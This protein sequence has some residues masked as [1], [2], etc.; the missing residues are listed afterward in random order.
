MTTLSLNFQSERLRFFPLQEEHILLINQ[1]HCLPM[2]AQ[3]NTIGIPKDIQTTANLLAQR[4][5]PVDKN[6]YGWA[7]FDSSKNFVGEAGMTLSPQR[8]KKAEIS[9][10]LHPNQWGIGLGT[11]VARRLIKF[12]FISLGLHRIEAGVA[13]SN[14]ASI[15][16]LEKAG[17]LR[18]GI[19][20]KILPLSKGWSDNF[21]YAILKEEW[22]V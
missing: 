3:F 17:M 4:L 15:R 10:S 11:E 9:Y 8:F 22:S 1:L 14:H 13:V 19:H 12:G 2:V 16:V 20:R 7:I 5:S 18:E 6:N 21:S